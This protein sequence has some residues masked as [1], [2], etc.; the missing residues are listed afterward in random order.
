[1]NDKRHVWVIEKYYSTKKTW[2][3][4][5]PFCTRKFAREFKKMYNPKINYR[6]IKYFSER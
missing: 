4:I 3:P 5:A 2:V 6:I 1:M